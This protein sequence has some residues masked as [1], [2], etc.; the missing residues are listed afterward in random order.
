MSHDQNRIPRERID[1]SVAG[2]RT[3]IFAYGEGNRPSVLAVHG[4]R[5]SHLGL[6]PLALALAE[7][8]Y[9]VLVPDL[10]GAGES[11][12]LSVQH[13]AA[14]YSEWLL[15]LVAIV[16]NPRI[17]LGHSF[18]T[19]IISAAIARG[20]SHENTVFVNPIVSPVLDNSNK[21]ATAA[22]QL[23]YALARWLP[24]SLSRRLL[25]STT[26]AAIGGNLMTR[27]DDRTLRRWIRDEH[28]RQAGAF[29][30]R[31]VVFE[32][33]RASTT[34]TINDFLTSIIKPTLI[35][36]AGRDPL[37]PLRA[38]HQLA[39]HI[40]RSAIHVFP[41]LG[42]LLPYEATNKCAEL[43]TAWDCAQQTLVLPG[44]IRSSS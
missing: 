28:R 30:T 32:S 8:G 25:A 34:T 3:A 23:Y 16:G 24:E 9:R 36:A 21:A 42:H 18:G 2:T 29:V 12:T 5:G 20:I 41:E 11:A 22:A 26:I 10:P 40:P 31:D 6:E 15:D 27:S 4:F 44:R 35:L 7:S 39:Q 13:D 43:V 33:Y 17:L 14:G 1:V 19:V 38:Q 37:S